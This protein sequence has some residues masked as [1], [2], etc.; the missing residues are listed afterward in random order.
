MIIISSAYESISPLSSDQASLFDIS[1]TTLSNSML[2]SMGDM[3]YLCCSPLL[4]SKAI[5]I[6][7][8]NFTLLYVLLLHSFTILIIFIGM[9]THLSAS[10]SLSL[11]MLS[12]ACL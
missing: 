11:S 4:I 2:K 1:R 12:L 7:F 10:Y 8:L 5:D 6:S 3:A 9:S